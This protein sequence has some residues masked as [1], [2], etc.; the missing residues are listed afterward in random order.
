MHRMLK[1]NKWIPSYIPLNIEN[2][3]LLLELL[4][5]FIMLP[6][7]GFCMFSTHLMPILIHFYFTM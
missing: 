3:I 7:S 5:K 1:G 4:D 6:L 2:H